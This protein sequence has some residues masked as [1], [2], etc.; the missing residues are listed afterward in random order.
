MYLSFEKQHR[1]CVGILEILFRSG[2]DKCIFVSAGCKIGQV[3][4]A[5]WNMEHPHQLAWHSLIQDYEAWVDY[6]Y[7]HV[8]YV[9]VAHANFPTSSNERLRYL[10]TA[11]RTM[12]L[13]CSCARLLA[14]QQRGRL[15]V[16]QDVQ[17]SW[18][19][20]SCMVKS[21]VYPAMA[22]GVQ[23][24]FLTKQFQ[25]SETILRLFSFCQKILWMPIKS[26][27]KCFKPLSV[28]LTCS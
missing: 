23:I 8:M 11:V 27:K 28:S 12:V 4:S 24:L 7:S 5:C 20:V 19:L 18:R 2:Q 1:L 9:R 21:E 17:R 26:G 13:L 25:I 6:P 14:Q 3:C 10:R 16:Q 15:Q 22:G